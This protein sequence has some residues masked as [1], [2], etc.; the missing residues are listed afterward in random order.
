MIYLVLL[1]ICIAGMVVVLCYVA[2]RAFTPQDI[3]LDPRSS[4]FAPL[5]RCRH[6]DAI[7]TRR[8]LREHGINCPKR[9]APPSS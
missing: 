6:C 7:V 9:P 3:Y 4:C 2:R 1:G 8:N 5:M